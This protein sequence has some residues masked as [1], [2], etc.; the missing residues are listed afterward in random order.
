MK[1]LMKTFMKIIKTPYLLLYNIHNTKKLLSFDS[2]QR[3]LQLLFIILFMLSLSFSIVSCNRLKK[4]MYKDSSVLSNLQDTDGDGILDSLDSDD[5]NDGQDDIIDVDDDNDGLIE[6]SSL[7]MLHNMRFNLNGTHYD[8]STSS[9]NAGC[10]TRGCNG[11]ELITDLNFDKDGDGSTFLEDSIKQCNVILNDSTPRKDLSKCKIDKD[12]AHSIYFPLDDGSDSAIN[13]GWQPIGDDD[14]NFKA[15]FEGNGHTISNLYSNRNIKTVGLFGTIFKKS[16]VRNIGLVRGLIHSSFQWASPGGLVGRNTYGGSIISSY[17]TG[18]VSSVSSL[19]W[20]SAGGLVG[21]NRG[22]IDSSYAT[23]D[24][25]S[26]SSFQW[27]SSGGLVGWNGG[28][29]SFSY[30]TGDVSASLHTSRDVSSH[31][32]LYAATGGLVGYNRIGSIN[33]SYA[34][35]DVSAASPTFIAVGGGLIGNNSYGTITSSYWNKDASQNINQEARSLKDKKG[36]GKNDKTK[37]TIGL[38]QKQFKAN[39]GAYPKEFK[40]KAWDLGTASQYPGLV[41][42]KCV[43]RPSGSAAEGFIVR[44]VCKKK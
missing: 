22:N 10:P 28:T 14:N 1:I 8:D 30:A 16:I 4:N 39:R 35:G 42:G 11:Y 15:I 6:I 23:G 34:T 19:Q 9:S 13:E 17:T 12:D 41:I 38:T 5:D 32:S 21:F 31:S 37:I 24:V 44:P 40:R 18:D 26:Y 43:H 33:F 29:I 2:L 3:N 27:A 25:S 20:A 36:I 7:L